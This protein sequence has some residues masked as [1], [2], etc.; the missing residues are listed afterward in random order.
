VA[1]HFVVH[2]C[3]YRRLIANVDRRS[4]ASMSCCALPVLADSSPNPCSGQ[5]RGRE[6]ESEA[7][8]RNIVGFLTSRAAR[9]VAF[10]TYHSYGERILT[11]WDYSKRILPHDHDDLVSVLSQYS[12]TTAN[13]EY[14]ELYNDTLEVGRYIENIVDLSPISIYRYRYLSGTLYICFRYTDK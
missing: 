12:T 9:F 7:E 10:I 13:A 6:A 4:R 5:Y 14:F 8:V 1:A 2:R 11:R 3:Q